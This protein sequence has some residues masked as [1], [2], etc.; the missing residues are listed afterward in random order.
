MPP[1]EETKTHEAA[2][3]AMEE[4]DD[5][6]EEEIDDEIYSPQGTDGAIPLADAEPFVSSSG[7]LSA[8]AGID[9]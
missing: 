7:N 5:F 1:E 6:V 4:S 9:S 8:S 3:S 2:V